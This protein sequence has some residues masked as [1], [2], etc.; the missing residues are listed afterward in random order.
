MPNATWGRRAGAALGEAFTERLGYKAAALF[1]AVALWIVASGEETVER[2]VPVQFVP[3][4]D[5]SVQLL[6]SAPKLHALVSGPTRELLKLY[7]DPPTVHHAFGAGTPSLVRLD[8]R[9]ADVDL[10]SG[11]ADVVVRDVEPHTLAL[12]FRTAGDRNVTV[13]VPPAAASAPDSVPRS[14]GARRVVP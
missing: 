14:D 8:L 9:V 1:F 6:G 12:R 2:S 11:L 3:T 5:G 4:L 7:R 10:P 13:S